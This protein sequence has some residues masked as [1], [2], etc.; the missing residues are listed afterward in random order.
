MANS[1]GMSPAQRQALV[2]QYR[3]SPHPRERLRAHILLLLAEGYSWALISAVLFCSTRTIARWKGR[4]ER[5]GMGAVLVPP[6]QAA[7]WRTAGWQAMVVYWVTELS[8][9]DF[10]FLRSRWCCGV[11]VLLLVET[12]DWH[13]SAETV[14]RW[15]QRAHMVWCRPR[16]VMGPTD[17]QRAAQ[18]AGRAPPAGDAAGQRNRRLPR[19]GR[20]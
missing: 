3:Q 2:A 1:I 12:Y 11:V 10:G 6:P 20:Y 9:R 7:P 19:R 15:L 4:V 5:E 13:V 8:P 16:P 18:A 17:P 14:R